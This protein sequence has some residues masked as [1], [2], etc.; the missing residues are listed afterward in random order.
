MSGKVIAISGGFGILGE[1]A[2]KG[3]LAKGWTV[4]AID[5]ADAPRE[6][7]PDGVDQRG[8]VDL[9]D[10]EATADLF[11]AIV[12]THE[13][14]DALLN[15]AGGFRWE[16]LEDGNIESW[17]FLYEI[18]VKTTAT[19]CKMALP[20]LKAA[21]A[22][23]I[24]N[25]GAAAAAL[26]AGMGMGAYTAS[27]SGVMRLT[28]ALA[29]E[30][31]STNVTVN[32]VLPS[33]IDTPQNRQDMPDTDPAIWVTPDDLASVMLFLASDEARAMTGALVPVTGKV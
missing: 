19:A 20:Y 3:A 25:V 12:E 5:R 17:D 16:T 30:L 22:G 6:T 31:K 1:A 18:N 10:A 24:V 27:K 21:P 14:L 23:R 33:I 29:E 28:E 13:R 2:V 11:N 15:I 8:G 7:F 26:K 9:T 4:V 32:A